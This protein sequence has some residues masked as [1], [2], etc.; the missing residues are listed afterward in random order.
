MKRTDS[1][2]GADAPKQL[3]HRRVQKMHGEQEDYNAGVSEI[4]RR[5]S[6]QFSHNQQRIIDTIHNHTETA[7]VISTENGTPHCWKVKRI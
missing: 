4:R 6:T 1:V 7:M 5:H 2:Q 3:M